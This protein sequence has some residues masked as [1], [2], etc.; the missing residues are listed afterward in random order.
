M[1]AVHAQWLSSP[2]GSRVR[3]DSN[4]T[5]SLGE[6][7]PSQSASVTASYGL[8]TR[9]LISA[10]YGYKYLNYR[11]SNYGIPICRLLALS[12]AGDRMCPV[13][14]SDTLDQ[15]EPRTTPAHLSPSK[16]VTTRHNLYI[17][18]QSSHDRSEAS[19]ISSKPGMRST[20]CSTI[21]RTD[22]PQAVS[23]CIG[24][25]PSRAA[26]LPT[27]VGDTGITSGR[28]VR[29]T[30]PARSAAITGFIFRTH[31]E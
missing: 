6:F 5:E 22:T 30:I 11:T 1:V 21:L 29:D 20:A 10:R 31:G 19:S 2:P 16:D 27:S 25:D 3:A 26:V 15:R 23:I 12:H 4:D 13:Y 7:V 14:P 28:M 8:D 18:A 9:T 17:D 24:D